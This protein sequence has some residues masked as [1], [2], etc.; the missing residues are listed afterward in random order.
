MCPGVMVPLPTEHG[1]LR[2]GSGGADEVF[3]AHF[4]VVLNFYKVLG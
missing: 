4:L 3:L 2:Q 1:E